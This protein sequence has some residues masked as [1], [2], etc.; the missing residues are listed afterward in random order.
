[1]RMGWKHLAGGLA[2]LFAAGMLVVWIGVI[3]ITASS[4]HW[5][6]TN[7]FLHWAMRSSIRTAAL[8]IEAPPL[9]NP[10]YLPLGAGHYETACTDCHGS[11][12]MGRS[13]AVLQ[14]LPP[15]PD[16]HEVVGEWTDE[17]LFQIVQHGVRYTGMPAWPA[18]NRD[19][20]VWAM[21]AFLRQYHALD[22]ESYRQ[23]A[24]FVKATPAGFDTALTV[25][26]GC[27]ASERLDG[28][29]LIPRLDGQSETY[30]L[31]SLKAFDSGARPSGVMQTAVHGLDEALMAELAR[32]YAA[33]PA[34]GREPGAGR[35]E[36]VARG[37]PARKIPACGSCHERPGVNPVFP[38][39]H[40]QSAAYLANQLRLFVAG[41][42]GGTSYSH[43]MTRAAHNLTEPEIEALA[44]YFG[45][46]AVPREPAATE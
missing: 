35:P 33:R 14:M 1:M 27:H 41:H 13:P 12:A 45:K 31:E 30:L 9:D 11:P 23:L 18:R 6:V 7:W 25:C 15:P 42:R 40:G 32:H 38:R 10:A 16:L 17:E 4:G 39:L 28:G 3:D 37:D 22:A 5:K 44:G 19:D 8:G 34:T 43:L 26:E 20:E 29:S 36:L 24:G 21:V 46:G 2:G